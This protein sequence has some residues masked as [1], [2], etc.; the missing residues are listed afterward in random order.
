M[1]AAERACQQLHREYMGKRYI[2]VFQCS[3]SEVKTALSTGRHKDTMFIHLCFRTNTIGG[4]KDSGGRGRNGSYQKDFG[5]GGRSGRDRG[6][7]QEYRYDN[8]RGYGN[9][10]YDSRGG[11]GAN[12]YDRSRPPKRR[13]YGVTVRV[14]G[15]PFSTTEDELADFFQEYNVRITFIKFLVCILLSRWILMM[16]RLASTVMA[17][18]VGMP[19]LPSHQLN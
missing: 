7:R 5:R 10:D 12:N 18:P 8:D 1:E 11:G 3:A 4:V 16:S 14:R 6:R 13:N 2:E 15:I 17:D 9:R 19:W